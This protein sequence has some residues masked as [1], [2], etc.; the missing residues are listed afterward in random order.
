MQQPDQRY[1]LQPQVFD[2]IQIIEDLAVVP[3][4]SVKTDATIV[5]V[6][7]VVFNELFVF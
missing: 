5:L 2:V 3:D 1:K 4:P 7:D 6:E